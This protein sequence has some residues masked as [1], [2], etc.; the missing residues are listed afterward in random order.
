MVNFVS[1]NCRTNI[2]FHSLLCN[3]ACPFKCLRV[4]KTIA[5]I[6]VEGIASMHGKYTTALSYATILSEKQI[7]QNKCNSEYNNNMVQ[8]VS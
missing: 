5:V 3:R 1:G 8:L 2:K 7:I 4:I 6:P